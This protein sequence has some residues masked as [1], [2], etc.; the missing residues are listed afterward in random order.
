MTTSA[1]PF[2]L[3]YK[4]L[5]T[6]I[7]ENR[8]RAGLSQEAVAL[9]AEISRPTLANI[10]AG[11]QRSHSH[12]LVLIAAAIGVTPEDILPAKPLRKGRKDRR[13]R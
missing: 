3:F 12:T 7:Q 9:D 8:L 11:R 1:R 2:S 10:E 13:T 4:T 5:G 6:N